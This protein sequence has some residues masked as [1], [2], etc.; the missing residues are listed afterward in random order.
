M[1]GVVLL[2]EARECFS[3]SSAKA[4]SR[5]GTLGVFECEVAAKTIPPFGSDEAPERW[6]MNQR[7]M[8]RSCACMNLNVGVL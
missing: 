8:A 4:R 5:V 1:V 7:M 6:S 2:E 3:S